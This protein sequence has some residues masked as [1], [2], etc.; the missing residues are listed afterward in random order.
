MNKR[1]SGV[2]AAVFAAAML[3]PSP[4]FAD[5]RPG[6]VVVIGGTMGL[7]GRYVEHAKL[8]LSARKL[9]VEEVNARGGLL[10][11]KVELKI[12][13]DKSDARTAIELYEKLVT[14]DKVDLI[15]GPYSS[16]ITDAVANVMERY[17]RPFIAPGAA[18][19]VIWQRGR[20]YVFNIPTAIAQDFQKG[21]LHLAAQIGVKRIAVIG[22]GSLFPRQV[23]E[24]ALKWAKKLDL[25]VVLLESYRKGQTEFTALLR[26]IEASG[27][28]A[29]FSSGY[30]RDS[31]AQARQLR[32]LNINVKLFAATT[33]A[34]LPKYIEELGSTAEYV[35]GYIT[36]MP[37]PVLLGHPGMKAFI[38]SYEK[39]YGEK[40]N[41]H[42]AGGYAEMQILEAAVKYAGSFDP[43]KLRDALASITVQTIRETYK[44]NEQGLST[45]DGLTFQIQNGKRVI[46][47]PAHQA[48]ARFLP[49]PKWEDRAK[50]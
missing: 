11:H 46:V 2:M 10:G 18:S 25:K 16:G 26:R 30:Y 28:E 42:V 32:E 49:M 31:V 22:E 21:A 47:S 4:A 33:G 39:R 38:D 34:A 24:G 23:T 36:W 40:P 27:A 5:H 43:E 14:G 8:Y 7:T 50:K 45:I 13:D 19:P 29:I 44:A 1:L 6:N 15:V 9:Y 20:R 37:K 12:L 35:V 48:E 3:F 41:S 17:K